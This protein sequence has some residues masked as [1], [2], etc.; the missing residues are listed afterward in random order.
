MASTYSTRT[1]HLNFI[2][3]QASAATH[4]ALPQSPSL[5]GKYN[6]VLSFL[7]KADQIW[8]SESPRSLVYSSFRWLL[9]F[10][11]I[12]DRDSTQE[13]TTLRLTAMA[14]RPTASGGKLSAGA[15][16]IQAAIGV[17]KHE[18]SQLPADSGMFGLRDINNFEL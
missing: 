5:V 3:K 14:T 13:T 4:T 8:D 15:P 12:L 9:P 17:V 16:R 18:A 7:P 6:N 10:L 1:S 11:P 2:S